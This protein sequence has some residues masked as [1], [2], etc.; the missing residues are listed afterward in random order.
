M[1]KSLMLVKKSLKK[2]LLENI[3]INSHSAFKGENFKEI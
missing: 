2:K 1:F 3:R